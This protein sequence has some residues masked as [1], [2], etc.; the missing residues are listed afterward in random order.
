MSLCQNCFFNKICANI[1]V[2]YWF[3]NSKHVKSENCGWGELNSKVFSNL[4]KRL[5]SL[6]YLAKMAHISM[7]WI[8]TEGD[9]GCKVLTKCFQPLTIITK[10]SILDVAAALD[11]PLFSE[12]GSSTFSISKPPF[13]FQH[14]L[15]TTLIL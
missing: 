14:Q 8:L 1:Y 5:T 13:F 6:S 12:N 9:V 10:R 15:E 11:P 4:K 7:Q 2:S 3:W